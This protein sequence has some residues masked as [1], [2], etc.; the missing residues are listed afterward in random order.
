MRGETIDKRGRRRF[1]VD[2]HNRSRLGD[3]GQVEALIALPE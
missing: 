3:A 1:S 2:R